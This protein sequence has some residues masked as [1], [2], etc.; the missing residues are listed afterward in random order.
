MPD[1]NI[2]KIPYKPVSPFIFW[3]QKTLPLVYDDSLSYYEVLCKVVDHLNRLIENEQITESNIDQLYVAYEQFKE[4]AE[5]YFDDLDVQTEINR[6]LD[7]MARTGELTELI[8]PLIPDIVTDWLDENITPTTP[9]VDDSLTIAEAAADAKAAGDWLRSIDSRLNVIPRVS[10]STSRTRD[11]TDVTVAPG[12]MLIVKAITDPIEYEPITFNVY[13]YKN[14]TWTSITSNKYT[15]GKTWYIE[16]EDNYSGIR[17]GFVGEEAPAAAF[18]VTAY[19]TVKKYH[20]ALALINTSGQN[21]KK[22]SILGASVSAYDGTIPDGYTKYYPYTGGNYDGTTYRCVKNIHDIYWQKVIDA[23]D[24]QLLVNNSSAGTY[25]TTGH[26][27]DSMAACGDRCTAL[28]LENYNDPDVIILQ[29]GMNDF[30]AEVGL[31]TYDGSQTFPATTTTFRE[32]YAIMLKKILARYR[33]AKVLA[34]TIPNHED[35]FITTGFPEKNDAGVLLS[36]YNQAIKDICDLFG[37]TVVD[38]YSCGITYQ[39]LSNFMQDFAAGSG[40]GMHPNRFG[41]SLMANQIIRAL[42]P[43]YRDFYQLNITGTF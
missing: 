27:N 23:L 42:D 1:S 32:A 14:A 21:K 40:Y 8:A 34:C 5:E 10:S 36:T 24:M 35:N 43:G 13:G 29:L 22:L 18:S 15:N 30:N 39:N 28:G 17:L 20:P 37:V 4:W 12:D 25:V 41:H 38:W 33:Y 16:I 9:V 19:L 2:E 26:G 7:Q 31:G 11:Y 3:A 6:K